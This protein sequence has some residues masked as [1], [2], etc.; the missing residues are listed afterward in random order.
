MNSLRL[1]ARILPIATI[2]VA[3]GLAGC[4]NNTVTSPGG[5]GSG[6]GTPLTTGGASVLYAI[7]QPSSTS[8]SI[9]E[10]SLTSGSGNLSPIATLTPP[11]GVFFSAIATDSSGLIY[12]GAEILATGQGEV[13][14]YPANSNGAV[15]PTRTILGGL[16]NT[17]TSFAEPLSMHVSSAG[18]LA[19]LSET[20]AGYSVATMPAATSTGTVTPT[21]LIQGAATQLTQGYS[22]TIDQNGKVYAT[23]Y[24][25]SGS[26]LEF[27]S[28]ATGNAAPTTV[29]TTGTS[30]VP[31]GIAA[32]ASGNVFTVL[33]SAT[34]N[35]T[36]ALTVYGA[37][38]A[39]RRRQHEPSQAALRESR[40]AVAC[41]WIQWAIFI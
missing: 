7:Q 5:T 31:Y 6:V 24:G 18:T 37:G 2:T 41:V 30:S 11:S 38:R 9:L 29:I 17:S 4:A 34:G 16:P 33:D 14:V 22:V 3:L 20:G 8:S 39:A 36:G 21:T 35:T 40:S 15:T 26:I 23:N 13:L 28:G 10:F 19:I 12:A 25:T 32:D 1:A 27:A